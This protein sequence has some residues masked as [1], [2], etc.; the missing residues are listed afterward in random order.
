[1]AEYAPY[2]ALG[3][4]IKRGVRNGAHAITTYPLP[5]NDEYAPLPIEQGDI[6]ESC[7]VPLPALHPNTWGTLTE[8]GINYSVLE[9]RS[10]S[11]PY[12]ASEGPAER[13]N[14]MYSYL[15][16]PLMSMGDARPYY[17]NAQGDSGEDYMKNSNI[18]WAYRYN[19]QMQEELR[20]NY[21][22]V[23]SRDYV[24]SVHVLPSSGIWSMARSEFYFAPR[25]QPHISWFPGGEGPNGDW[26]FH[27]GWIG[28]LRPVVLKDEDL[29]VDPSEMWDDAR[30]IVLQ[31]SLVFGVNPMHMG[32]DLVYMEKVST[33][34]DGEIGNG[35]N[36][37]LDGIPK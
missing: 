13:V 12:M 4:G 1:M 8:W 36:E 34:M 24:S 27:P 6:M 9:D 22:A 31:Q 10:V 30:G 29:P 11:S 37:V 33:G 25:N 23:I 7:E 15:G 35:N 28:K 16:C 32:E 3:E 2:W 20:D 5:D 19:P 21:D 18:V 14:I 17:W 26:L